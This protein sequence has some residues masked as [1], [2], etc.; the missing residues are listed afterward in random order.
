MMI[1]IIIIINIVP[2]TDTPFLLFSRS[3][4]PLYRVENAQRERFSSTL[5]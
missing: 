5:F 1:T 3:L 4:F 2:I